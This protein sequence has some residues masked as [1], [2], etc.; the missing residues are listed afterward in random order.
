M[1]NTRAPR[2]LQCHID[3]K[4]SLKIAKEL[5][6]SNLRKRHLARNVYSKLYVCFHLKKI[7]LARAQQ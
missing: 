2:M 7:K 1:E 3:S 4:S 6:L 5:G